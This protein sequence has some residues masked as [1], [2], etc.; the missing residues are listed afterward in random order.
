MREADAEGKA[1]RPRCLLNHPVALGLVASSR[2][3]AA[4]PVFSN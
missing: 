1:L 3:P 2:L 4:L